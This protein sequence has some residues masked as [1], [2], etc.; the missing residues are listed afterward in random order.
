MSRKKLRD[1]TAREPIRNVVILYDPCLGVYGIWPVGFKSPRDLLQTHKRR[2]ECYRTLRDLG[3]IQET[4]LRWSTLTD[5]VTAAREDSPFS[6]GVVTPE[7]ADEYDL[8]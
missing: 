2:R 1:W 7:I 8:N 6:K 5:R 4:K 3:Y